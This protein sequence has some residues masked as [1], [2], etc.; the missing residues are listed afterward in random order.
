MLRRLAAMRS[1]IPIRGK[2]HQV[3]DETMF[4]AAQDDHGATDHR[5]SH[6]RRQAQRR[7]LAWHAFSVIYGIVEIPSSI[8]SCFSRSHGN[9][10]YGED[11]MWLSGSMVGSVELEHLRANDKK[12]SLS[13]RMSTPMLKESIFRGG[14]ISTKAESKLMIPSAIRLYPSLRFKLH[15]LPI[16]DLPSTRRTSISYAKSN[17]SSPCS[18]SQNPK[19]FSSVSITSL[20]SSNLPMSPRISWMP[21]LLHWLLI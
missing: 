21:V 15:H 9:E 14:D 18:L 16:A 19:N 6:C 12:P 2:S 5:R 1:Q 11:G 7:G 20:G 10:D 17:F 13:D 3:A 8:L 4:R